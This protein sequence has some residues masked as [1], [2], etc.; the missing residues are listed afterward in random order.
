LKKSREVERA[1][2]VEPDVSDEENA[3]KNEHGQER[4]GRK[5][6]GEPP[7]KQDG[8]GKEKYRF[9][10]EDYEEHGDDVEAGRVTATGAG[11]REDAAFIRL[12]FG[13]TPAGA[14]ADVL[15]GDER[16]D[17]KGNDQQGEEQERDVGWWHWL[18]DGRMLTQKEAGYLEGVPI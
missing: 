10:F 13:G 3:K 9:H 2:F 16:D 5:M 1:F 18:A 15:E 11:F 6:R 8:P 17:W 14:G 12:K 7:T 4:E